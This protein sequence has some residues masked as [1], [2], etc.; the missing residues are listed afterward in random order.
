MITRLET[1]VS[2]YGPEAGPA[3]DRVLQ[4]QAAHAGVSRRLRRRLDVLEGR[5]PAEVKARSR[6]LPLFPNIDA[7]AEAEPAA[8]GDRESV[9]EAVEGR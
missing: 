1:F 8:A 5:A 9:P 6:P 4:S 7:E 2:K 3:L